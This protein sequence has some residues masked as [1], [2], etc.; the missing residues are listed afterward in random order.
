LTVG[1]K[2]LQNVTASLAPVN[3]PLL[4]GQSFLSR[5]KSWSIDNQRQVLYLSLGPVTERVSPPS[6]PEEQG[7]Q[8][9]RSLEPA[10]QRAPMPLSPADPTPGDLY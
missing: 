7:Q 9:Q 1:D 4:L 2:T 10:P 8:I 3:G 6:K 5:F